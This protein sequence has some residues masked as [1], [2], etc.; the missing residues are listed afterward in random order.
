MRRLPVPQALAAPAEVAIAAMQVV[1]RELV[2]GL[3]DLDRVRISGE[4]ALPLVQAQPLQP[5]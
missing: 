3:E 4:A 2:G 1:E 5:V